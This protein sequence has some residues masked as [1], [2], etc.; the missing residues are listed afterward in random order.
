MEAW[1]RGF[2]SLVGVHHANLWRTIDN[3]QKEQ[4]L[5]YV[6]IAQCTA[7]G[8]SPAKKRR[9]ADVNTH[10]QNLARSYDEETTD[11]IHYL[12]GIAHN[13]EF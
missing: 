13:L 12:R 1:H 9:Y 7:G 6:T 2:E 8:P 3:F 5:N 4:A 10:L 11:T